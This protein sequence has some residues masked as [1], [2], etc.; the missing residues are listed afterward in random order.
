MSH[1]QNLI[2]SSFITKYAL[3]KFIRCVIVCMTPLISLILVLLVA[4]TVLDKNMPE[5]EQTESIIQEAPESTEPELVYVPD[6]SPVVVE[7][8]PVYELINLA[9]Y[10]VTIVSV[11][12]F[13]PTNAGSPDKS[14]FFE[15]D[16]IN[17]QFYIS[18]FANDNEL[19][20]AYIAAIDGYEEHGSFVI[21]DMGRTPIDGTPAMMFKFLVEWRAPL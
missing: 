6:D 12:G 21:E 14:L 10:G 4:Q 13:Q 9:P 19:I 1:K 18:G 5:Q 7:T 8:T 20:S 3:K 15:S 11:D 2:T 16:I 17:N